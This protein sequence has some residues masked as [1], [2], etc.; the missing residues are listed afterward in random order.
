MSTETQII[1]PRR[2]FLIRALGFTAA[3][4]TVAVPITALADP[5]ARIDHHCRE[6]EKALRDRYGA[7]LIALPHLHL[8]EPGAIGF[9]QSK[10]RSYHD[11]PT[12]VFMGY[13]GWID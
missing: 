2:N 10:G 13:G 4:A 8:P 11:R 7:D 9:D 6:L 5:Q 1:T 12:L 3:G